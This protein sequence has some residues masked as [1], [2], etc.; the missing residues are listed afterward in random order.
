M[1]E[2]AGLAISGIALVSLFST[3]LEILDY[4]EQGKNWSKDVHISLTKVTLMKHRLRE[5]GSAM[6]IDS[7]D[8]DACKLHDRWPTESGVI[9]QSMLGIRDILGR[10][11]EMCRRHARYADDVPSMSGA[12]CEGEELRRDIKCHGSTQPTLKATF[13]KSNSSSRSNSFSR[14]RVLASLHLKLVWVFSDKG[15]LECLIADFD[16]LLSNLEKVSQHLRRGFTM[17][18]YNPGTDGE[19]LLPPPPPTLLIFA[20]EY[21]AVHYAN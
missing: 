3:S 9:Y 17:A 12:G 1:A 2:V 11:T 7:L 4:F 21:Y 18:S 19:Q 13:L 5:W 20:T 8:T 14:R 16:F 6:A 10:A 15:K